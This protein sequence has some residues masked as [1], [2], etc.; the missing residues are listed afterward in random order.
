MLTIYDETSGGHFYLKTYDGEENVFK[1]A[2]EI[3]ANIGYIVQFPA[4]FAGSKIRF[5]SAAGVTLRNDNELTPQTANYQLHS[6][7]NVHH[8][9]VD[10]TGGKQYYRYN[11]GSNAFELF[12]MIDNVLTLPPL[13]SVVSVKQAIQGAPLR[14]VIGDGSQADAITGV[15]VAP[16]NEAIV[17]VRYYNLQGVE[18]PVETRRA[19]SLPTGV[20]IVKTIYES[21][22][23]EVSKTIIKNKQQ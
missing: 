3:A 5:V 12:E 19:T 18:I 4:Y 1:Y 22:K 9:G 10:H 20:Y 6:H 21:G 23:S 2:S 13:E 14:R 16:A 17:A 11:T 15:D 7:G 8:Y